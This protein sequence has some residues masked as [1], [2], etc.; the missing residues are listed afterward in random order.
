MS[1]FGDENGVLKLSRPLPVC[2]DG[3]PIVRPRDILV[4]SSVDHWLYGENVACFHETWSLVVR[5][6][7]DIGSHVEFLP[8]PMA[9]VGPVDREPALTK[10]YPFY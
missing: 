4:D 6:V 1:S 3:R 9:A 7:R 5:V 2:C 10:W 8:Y